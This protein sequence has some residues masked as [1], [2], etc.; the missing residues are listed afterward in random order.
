MRNNPK[1][2][3]KLEYSELF[4]KYAR[5]EKIR[6]FFSMKRQ[7]IYKHFMMQHYQ[8]NFVRRHINEFVKAIDSFLKMDRKLIDRLDAVSE[9]YP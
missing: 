8:G 1:Y 5:I 2:G 3:T 4:E 9:F 6:R 7:K